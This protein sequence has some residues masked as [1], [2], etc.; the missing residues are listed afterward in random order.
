[1]Q[2]AEPVI[3]AKPMARGLPYAGGQ[4]LEKVV[5]KDAVSWKDFSGIA[6]MTAT[7]R[8]TSVLRK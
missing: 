8:S 3:L 7:G 4:K 1:M 6:S 2:F 5:Q